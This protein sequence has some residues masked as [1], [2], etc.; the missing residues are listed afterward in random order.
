MSTSLLYHAC[1]VRG[2]RYQRTTFAGGEVF[3][4]VTA[5]AAVCRC[6][7]CGS[8]QVIRRGVATRRFRSVPIGGKL[9][10]I[11]AELPRV[12]CRDCGAIR[13][14]DIGFAP[15]RCSYTKAFAAYALE[16]TR[17]MTIKDVAQHLCVSWDLIKDLKKDFLRRRFAKPSLKDVRRIAIDETNIGH[18]HRYLTIVLDLDRGAILFAAPGKKAESLTPFW[19]RLRHSG[20]CI[21]AVA[22]DMSAAYISAVDHNLPQ[23]DIVFDRFHVMK[24]FNQKLS[25]LRRALYRQVVNDQQ[26]Q[27]LKG[28]RWLLLKNPENL[29][30][31]R[32]ERQRLRDALALNEP[33]S[34]AYYLKDELR[35]FW[36]Q[37][38]KTAARDFIT[39]WYF[40]A[41]NSGVRHVME[42]ARTLLGHLFGLLTYFKHRIS[43]GPLEGT[44]NKIKTL[45]KIS[46]G[47]RDQEYFTLS[48]YALHTTKY[49]LVG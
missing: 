26:R 36:N 43:T 45:Q 17:Y 33:L 24:L 18:G 7:C 37:P 6:P 12:E 35:Q 5:T 42:F 30:D 22:M 3:F 2:Y 47:L 46:Y 14:I 25:D 23:A 27:V 29:C 40:R 48:L 10:W 1:G 32:Q 31:E 41:M 21:T 13:Q 20:A 34:I 49:A 4:H 28:V 44:N 39:S 11:M 16:L 19:H 38:H 9:V 15:P 8:G